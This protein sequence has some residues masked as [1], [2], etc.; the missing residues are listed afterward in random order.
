[1]FWFR[2]WVENLIIVCLWRERGAEIFFTLIFQLDFSFSHSFTERTNDRPLRKLFN[3]LSCFF[4]DYFA[5]HSLV[6][7]GNKS[8]KF[9]FSCHCACQLTIF[10]HFFF[11]REDFSDFSFFFF[12][13]RMDS[14]LGQFSITWWMILLAYDTGWMLVQRSYWANEILSVHFDME[15]ISWEIRFSLNDKS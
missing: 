8:K 9:Q 2:D 4:F 7:N 10:L 15:K 3:F 5:F 14:I 11:T 13:N 12:F 1:M 6:C